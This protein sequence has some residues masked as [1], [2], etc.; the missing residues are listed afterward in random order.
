TR[1]EGRVR[2]HDG[3]MV[4]PLQPAW[5]AGATRASRSVAPVMADARRR[6][7]WAF[8]WRIVFPSA[9]APD[10]HITGGRVRVDVHDQHL[11]RDIDIGRRPVGA[12]PYGFR[13]GARPRRSR[14]RRAVV[15]GARAAAVR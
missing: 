8:G 14:A 6:L 10:V 11:A 9:A 2:N 15:H 4:V 13:H 1:S 5:T 12:L 7:G 3:S